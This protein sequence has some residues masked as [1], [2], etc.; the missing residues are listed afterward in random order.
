VIAVA[1]EQPASMLGDVPGGIEMSELHRFS[2]DEYHQLIDSG[3]LDEET[4]VE[5]IDG[6]VVEMS[7][8]T[9][10][11]ERAVRWLLNELAR[12]VDLTRYRLGAGSAL[13]LERSEP[14]P[15]LIVIDRDTP[16]PYHPATAL[17]VIE[18][19]APRCGAT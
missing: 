14:E 11:H 8:T 1:S 12:V 13:T 9:P 19:S 5:L 17:L 7:P 3:G 2:L 18:V 4:R 16:Q 10:K 15:D 6:L